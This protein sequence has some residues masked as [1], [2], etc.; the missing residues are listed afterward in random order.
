MD[1]ISNSASQGVENIANSMGGHLKSGVEDAK[2]LWKHNEDFE[3]HS[4]ATSKS[5]QNFL[6]RMILGRHI[7]TSKEGRYTK[8]YYASLALLLGVQLS[9]YMTIGMIEMIWLKLTG[10][11]TGIEWSEHNLFKVWTF[12]TG[13]P[14]SIYMYLILFSIFGKLLFTDPW[15]FLKLI[16]TIVMWVVGII[17]FFKVVVPF[18]LKLNKTTM[19]TSDIDQGLEETKLLKQKE[20]QLQLE[21]KHKEIE[22]QKQIEEQ[23]HSLITDEQWGEEFNKIFEEFKEVSKQIQPYINESQKEILKNI[24]EKYTNNPNIEFQSALREL[25]LEGA[26]MIRI[27]DEHTK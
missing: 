16:F 13:I 3:E 27:R 22:E 21:L 8:I 1:D 25:H 15:G 6:K 10:K 24:E 14:L 12:I 19:D 23:K 11:R 26:E 2:M 9:S 7:G 4:K 20:R 17:V 18:L 5:N